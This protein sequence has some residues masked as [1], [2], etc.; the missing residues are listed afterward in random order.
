MPGC[1]EQLNMHR[2]SGFVPQLNFADLHGI[3]KHRG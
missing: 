1:S 2:E 3:E